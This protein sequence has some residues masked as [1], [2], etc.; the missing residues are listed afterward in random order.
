MV[1]ERGVIW[2]PVTAKAG[3]LGRTSV[4]AWEVLRAMDLGGIEAP[5]LQGLGLSQRVPRKLGPHNERGL[6]TVLHN[7][8]N[9][10]DDMQCP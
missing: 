2:R 10:S 9:T 5:A 1:A 4:G 3:F 7:H 8:G 6:A